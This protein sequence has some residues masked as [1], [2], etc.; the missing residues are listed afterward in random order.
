MKGNKE[1][2]VVLNLSPQNDLLI[3]IPDELITGVYKNV[4]TGAT[5]DL[6]KE[7]SFILQG[8]EFFVYEK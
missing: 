3:N 8:W 1:V 2:L 4:F 6:T 5:N 7:K